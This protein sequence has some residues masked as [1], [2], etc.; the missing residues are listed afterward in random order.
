MVGKSSQSLLPT[1]KET[2]L[3]EKLLGDLKTLPTQRP[4]KESGASEGVPIMEFLPPLLPEVP[5]PILM[6]TP[7][8]PEVPIPT[9]QDVPVRKP[10]VTPEVSV[11]P[12]TLKTKSLTLSPRM[13]SLRKPQIPTLHVQELGNTT[14][15]TRSTG[16]MEEDEETSS[17]H[18]RGRG[19]LQARRSPSRSIAALRSSSAQ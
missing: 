5:T 16:N 19:D 9:L 11:V 8:L 13:L 4:G 1:Q 18:S 7:T 6:E 2:P 14:E 3:K 15:E 17:P 12:N 10:E